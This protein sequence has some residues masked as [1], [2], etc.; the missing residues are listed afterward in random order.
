M[1]ICSGVSRRSYHI[2]STDRILTD[3]EEYRVLRR[4]VGLMSS[5]PTC[6]FMGAEAFSAIALDEQQR[7]TETKDTQSILR[8]HFF[9]M[10]DDL[11]MQAQELFEG[12]IVSSG[13]IRVQI[14]LADMRCRISKARR[15]WRSRRTSSLLSPVYVLHF[16]ITAGRA[17]ADVLGFSWLHLF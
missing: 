9:A 14:R 1:V 15:P 5:R 8:R 6:S 10:A 13:Y 16:S 2:P 4:M 12:Q 3:S 11:L 7:C 17:D